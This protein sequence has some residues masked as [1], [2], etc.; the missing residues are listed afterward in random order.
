MANHPESHE[1]LRLRLAEILAALGDAPQ[2]DEAKFKEF[3]LTL[4]RVPRDWLLGCAADAL[5]EY[6]VVCHSSRPSPEHDLE[7]QMH[8]R[9]ELR[10]YAQAIREKI[11]SK[12]ELEDMRKKTVGTKG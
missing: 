2:F 8:F 10:V 11:G 3:E 6:Y 12:R 7:Q 5:T 9:A 4:N 1:A